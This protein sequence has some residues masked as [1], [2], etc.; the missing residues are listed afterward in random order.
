MKSR[1]APVKDL[2]DEFWDS[3]ASGP[4]LGELVDLLLGGDFTGD[5][6]P[7]KTFGQWLLPTGGLGKS[8]LDIGDGFAAETD[9][10]LC[11]K[12]WSWRMSKG[13]TKKRL[14]GI[15]NGAIPNQRGQATHA[16]G[17]LTLEGTEK[18]KRKA[19][20]IELVDNYGTERFFAMRSTGG[21]YL[22]RG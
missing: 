20:P 22:E 16:T 8:L 5:E 2:L 11:L 3:S 6:E 9:A 21:L 15:Q 13:K 10:L 14:T 18:R 17:P 1:W 19:L 7:E 12:S 4:V